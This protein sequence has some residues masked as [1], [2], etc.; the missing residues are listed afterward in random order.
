MVHYHTVLFD[1]P[2]SECHALF[3]LYFPYSLL[4]HTT[5]Y[6][7]PSSSDEATDSPVHSRRPN[8]PIRDDLRRAVIEKIID[9]FGSIGEVSRDLC[10]AKSTMNGI[11]RRFED[12][13]V[14]KRRR[15]GGNRKE[16]VM[17][18][19]VKQSLL[20]FID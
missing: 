10:T 2:L 6:I 13:G 17:T 11:V 12:H 8:Q 14:I 4:S 20:R 5:L 1:Y 9:E 19:K 3:A 7:M 16:I 18:H 15:T